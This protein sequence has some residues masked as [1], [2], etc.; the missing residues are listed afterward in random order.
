V[1]VP[2]SI[3]P[4]IR[5]ARTDDGV[6]IAFWTLGDGRPTFMDSPLTFSHCSLEFRIPMIAA[7]YEHIAANAMLIRWD[8]RNYGMS[9][10]GIADLGI[11]DFAADVI[12]VADAIGAD[13]FDVIG[14]NNYPT[15]AALCPDR[16][17]RMA[18]VAPPPLRLAE[19]LDDPNQA[20]VRSLAPTNWDVFTETHGSFLQGWDPH[21]S[22]SFARF[23]RESVDQADYLRIMDAWRAYD[24][25]EY[26]GRIRCPTLIVS[27]SQMP[28]H[29]NAARRYAAAINGSR[30][31]EVDHLS[32]A[33]GKSD[34]DT[35]RIVQDFLA[36]GAT[37]RRRPSPPTA[38]AT[39]ASPNRF[40]TVLFTDIVEHTAM[41]QRLGDVAGREVLREHE[42]VT[43]RTL[44][45]YDGAEVK[46][47]GDGFLASFDSVTQAMRCAVALQQAFAARRSGDGASRSA[48]PI[49]IRIGINAG[50][51]IEEDGDLFGSTVIL[52]S[53]IAAAAAGGEILIPEAVRHLLAGKAFNFDDRGEA[54]LKGFEDPVRLFE[55]RWETAQI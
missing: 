50:E 34:A 28:L 8:K 1:V 7:L 29:R 37:A 51:P 15:V 5:Y 40:R 20:A 17:R 4:Q 23:I 32:H 53:R 52:A 49:E 33:F 6:S 2:V 39:T 24:I 55:V 3:D 42:R 14:I 13:D 27:A 11:E 22:V 47:M 31:V 36:D 30:L 21:P 10:R 43:R 46:T 9:Q 16:V 41:M 19:L 12:A 26:L 44:E 54:V 25:T 38:A 18:L 48:E 35:F 45:E